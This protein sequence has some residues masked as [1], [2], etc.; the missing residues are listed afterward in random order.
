MESNHCEKEVAREGYH[1]KWS[2]VMKSVSIIEPTSSRLRLRSRK[3]SSV[4][5]AI[6]N[7]VSGEAIPGEVL[8]LMGPSGSGKTSLLDIISCR[9]SMNSGSYTLDC[10]P[11][12]GRIMKR[13]K[14]KI[15]YVKQNDIFFDHLTVG[16]QITY[17]AQLRLQKDIG[18]KVKQLVKM[19]LLDACVDTPIYLISG[20]EKKRLNIGTEL[21]TDPF[22]LVLDEPTSGLDSTCAVS[23]INI[24]HKFARKGKT[25]ITSIHQPSSGIFRSFDKICFLGEGNCIYFGTPLSSL[26]YMEGL[27]NPCPPGYNSADHWMD[28]LVNDL[29]LVKQLDNDEEK[30]DDVLQVSKIV[31]KSHLVR[32]WALIVSSEEIENG[33]ANIQDAG[34]INLDEKFGKR[35]STS[36]TTQ[37]FVLLHRSMKNSRSA[38]FTPLNL[39]KS[40]VIG[41]MMGLI[42]F[43][44]PYTESTVND[45][46][47]Y[48]FFTMTFWVFDAMFL[49]F[50]QF[51]IE[52]SIIL[53]ERESGCYKLS[54]Y[55]IAKTVSEAPTR[56]CLPFI[57]MCISY[58]V[59]GINPSIT[60]FVC[61]TLCTL[62]SV[63][64]GESC[65][66]FVGANF[67]DFDKGMV[68]MV[69]VSLTLM[70]VGGFFVQN[71]PSFIAWLAYLSPFKY[72][73][74]AS[75]Q[76]VFDKPVPCDGSGVL[77]QC[78]EGSEGS[79]SPEDVIKFLG[80]NGTILFNVSMLTVV[81]LVPRYFAYV[82]LTRRKN[83]ER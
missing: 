82:S 10:I 32:A 28:V 75:Q 58:W 54:A 56:L 62:L 40:A 70:V 6:L 17:T 1:L 66:L 43:Q 25:I 34:D 50:M 45:R 26:E 22:V 42:W 39:I 3:K 44:L 24:L 63:L 69:I 9:S 64:A 46:V 33:E 67:M 59:A 11:V 23:L 8:A 31:R 57:Y 80:V 2:R 12:A 19:L 53:K 51:P 61:S 79:V 36:W 48:Y 5:K 77:V 20:G 18:M 55:F 37:L 78:H 73:F 21:L 68:V 71:I 41:L 65:G 30:K 74:D 7:E 15:A 27:G 83:E 13:L 49:A 47:S 72:S 16:E 60:V 35:Y 14:R 38:I 4:T 81:F 52:R 76:I 29:N